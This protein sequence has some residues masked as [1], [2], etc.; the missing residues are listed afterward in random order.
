[1]VEERE[2]NTGR[3]LRQAGVKPIEVVLIK[4]SITALLTV[5]HLLVF[6]LLNDYTLVQI[7]MTLLL[8]S[9]VTV[10]FLGLGALLGQASKNTVD[11]SLYAWPIILFYFLVESLVI[12]LEP[13]SGRWFVILPN[14]HVHYG[15]VKL[16][17]GELWAMYLIVPFMW[18]V[19]AVRMVWRVYRA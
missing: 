1:M 15:M 5:L 6:F 7:F 2:Q 10:L 12:N 8:V 14:Y 3:V 18:C 17:S 19:V 16:Q 11:V 9:P 4:T 13:V